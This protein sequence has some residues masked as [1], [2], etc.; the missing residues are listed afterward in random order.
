[1][2]A[3]AI[4]GPLGKHQWDISLGELANYNYII[5]RQNCETLMAVS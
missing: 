3:E 2:I 4:K 1:M 5:V